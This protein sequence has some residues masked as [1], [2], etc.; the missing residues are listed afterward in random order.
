MK[1]IYEV[2]VVTENM[3]HIRKFFGIGE[4]MQACVEAAI[5]DNVIATHIM[6]CETGEI[7]FMT[8]NDEVVWISGLGDPRDF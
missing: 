5:C 6:D 8:E 3:K 2:S 1:F 7:L 4:A